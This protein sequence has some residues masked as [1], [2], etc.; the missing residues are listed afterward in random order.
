MATSRT[1]RSSAARRHAKSA[2]SNSKAKNPSSASIPA[3]PHGLPKPRRRSRYAAAVIPD[4][5]EK[6]HRSPT[7][8]DSVAY[9]AGLLRRPQRAGSPLERRHQGERRRRP[10]WWIRRRR[11]DTDRKRKA[12]AHPVARRRSRRQDDD[13]CDRK[14][15]V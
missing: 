9:S 10:Y 1:P 2:G 14:S 3:A 15:V 5:G 12:V 8:S 11:A 4:D 7:D 13:G 6:T